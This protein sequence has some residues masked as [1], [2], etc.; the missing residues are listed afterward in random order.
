MAPLARCRANIS[1]TFSYR[2]T[3]LSRSRRSVACS[4]ER[5]V[6]S[7][8]CGRTT[9]PRQRSTP[10]GSYCLGKS[11]CSRRS[12]PTW[13]KCL[14][15]HSLSGPGRRRN[16]SLDGAS[17]IAWRCTAYPRATDNCDSIAYGYPRPSS[18]IASTRFQS[19]GRLIPALCHLTNV[20]ADKHFSDAA[21]PKWLY[22]ACS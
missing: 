17:R 16:A 8:H 22:C 1:H 9:S 2:D 10:V 20:A 11:L 3:S 12:A 18:N 5:G 7:L 21:S 15:L 19:F 6:S 13:T 14:D 4:D